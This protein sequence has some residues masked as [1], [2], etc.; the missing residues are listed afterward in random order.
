MN[1]PV[2]PKSHLAGNFS[3]Y[4]APPNENTTQNEVTRGTTDDSVQGWSHASTSLPPAPC[5]LLAALR[6]GRETQGGSPRALPELPL[7]RSQPGVSNRWGILETCYS[8]KLFLKFRRKRTASQAAW[9]SSRPVT[10]DAVAVGLPGAPRGG[11][12]LPV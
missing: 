2:T 9:H 8:L 12:R 5:S 6:A 11:P 1:P 10:R 4:P 3:F 7:V